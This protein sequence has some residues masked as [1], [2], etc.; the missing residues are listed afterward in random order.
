MNLNDNI[1]IKSE[2]ETVPENDAVKPMPSNTTTTSAP[3][4]IEGVPSSKPPPFMAET[5]FS[6]EAS[7][8]SALRDHLI[9]QQAEQAKVNQGILS[10]MENI[11]KGNAI[12]DKGADIM[13]KLVVQSKDDTF[14]SIPKECTDTTMGEWMD[15]N[16]SI[17]S[18]APWDIDRVSIVDM[19]GVVLADASSHY[20]AR[21]TKLGMIMRQLLM[22]A[23]LTD[24]I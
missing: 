7:Q 22:N 19:K 8:I 14:P 20:R 4:I 11:G 21:F 1:S 23:G 24:N 17:L 15:T 13:T 18:A 10:A 9:V 6:D 3:V 12:N 16:K 5:V 2:L